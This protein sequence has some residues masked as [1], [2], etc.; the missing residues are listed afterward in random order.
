MSKKKAVVSVSDKR[1]PPAAGAERAR[2]VASGAGDAARRDRE[3]LT[4]YVDREVLTT[5]RVFCA[6]SRQELSEVTTAALSR[7]LANEDA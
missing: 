5:L 6:R 2:F 1:K 7:F 4:I 3:K